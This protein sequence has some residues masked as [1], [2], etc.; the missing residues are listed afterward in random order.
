MGIFLGKGIN[1]M[2]SSMISEAVSEVVSAAEETSIGHAAEILVTGM[3]I[4]F[5]VLILLMAI[6]YI[7]KA[8]ATKG[9]KV[10]ETKTD[11]PVATAAAP[12]SSAASSA[13]SDDESQLAAVLTAAIAAARG[14]SECAFNIISIKK[15]V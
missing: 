8:F 3:A 2:E 11:A 15:I 9:N 4:V 10:A 1:S 14:E 7:F 12:V 5:G 13:S 6:L